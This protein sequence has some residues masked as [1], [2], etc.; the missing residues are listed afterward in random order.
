MVDEEHDTSYKQSDSPRYHARDVAIMRATVGQGMGVKAS[1]GIGNYADAVGM[2]E[3]G[4]TR[5]ASPHWFGSR[6]SMPIVLL[7]LSIR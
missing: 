6:V 2:I 1:G 7:R 3:A 4:A 5:A